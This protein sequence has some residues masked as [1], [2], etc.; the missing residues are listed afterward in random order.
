MKNLPFGECVQEIG[1]TLENKMKWIWNDDIDAEY[2][3]A[4]KSR[5]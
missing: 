2:E 3:Q 1:R 4:V 5:T